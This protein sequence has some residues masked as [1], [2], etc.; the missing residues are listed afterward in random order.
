MCYVCGRYPLWY[1]RLPL[2]PQV[3]FIPVAALLG[4]V[5][6]SYLLVQCIRGWDYSS[7]RMKVVWIVLC[8]SWV[9]TA[10]I[11]L[12][13]VDPGYIDFTRGLRDWAHADVDSAAIRKWLSRVPSPENV[14]DIGEME[15]P[16]AVKSLEPKY[17]RIEQNGDF[18]FLRLTWGGAWAHWGIVVSAEHRLDGFNPRRQYTLPVRTGLYAWH[19]LQ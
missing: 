8:S 2:P 1:I 4:A 19:E 16:T 13:I 6:F 12:S 17:V 9:F 10:Y 18:R 7:I 15:W 11:S 14:R 5:A 3:V